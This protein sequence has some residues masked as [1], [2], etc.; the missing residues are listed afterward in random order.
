MRVRLKGIATSYAKG[1]VYYYAWRGGPRLRGEPGSADFV[2]SYNEAVAARKTPPAGNIFA[3]VA[4]FKKAEEFRTLAPR[5]QAD[6]LGHMRVI[7]NRF[8][9][10]PLAALDDRRVRGIFKDWRD[11]LAV[12]SRRQADYAWTVLAR[13]LAVAKD[14]GTIGTNP[15]ERG[16]RIYKA[17]R[18]ERVWTDQDEAAFLAV[19]PRHLHLALLLA[20]WTGQ[21]QGDLL[22]LTWTNYDGKVIRLRQSKTG[23]RVTIPVGAPLRAALDAERAK[24]R[25]AVILLN[26]EGDPWTADG[27]RSSWGKAC[28]K[29]GIEGLTFHDTRGTAVTRLALEHASVPE[30]ATLT[31]LS[32]IDVQAILDAH[33]LN[34]DPALAERAVARLEARTP[35]ER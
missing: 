20:L 12:R 11:E 26:S 19:A 4:A 27:F 7:E 14:R 32:L 15:C 5:T 24:K 21:R 1:K 30:I 35:K 29:A 34:R 13:I 8:G 31:G 23:T 33:Y 9:N 6:Y 22:R 25:G 28:D 17:D 18:S 3:L 2:A 16:G 10:M